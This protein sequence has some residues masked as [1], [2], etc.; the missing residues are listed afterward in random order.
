MS[1]ARCMRAVVDISKSLTAL[2]PSFLAIS[3]TTGI[4]PTADS[5]AKIAGVAASPYWPATKFLTAS[6]PYLAADATSAA[7]PAGVKPA[8]ICAA[9]GVSS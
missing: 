6:L 3:P 2:L 7:S 9:K 8:R 5:E 1:L 4:N